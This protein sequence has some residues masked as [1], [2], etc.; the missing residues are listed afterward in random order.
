[1]TAVALPPTADAAT[2][3]NYN[4]HRRRVGMMVLAGLFV[5]AGCLWLAYWLMWGRFEAYTDDAYVH[6]NVVQVAPQVSGT[7]T[8]ILTDDTQ[9]VFQNQE[10]VTLD[11]ADTTLA[12]QHAKAKLAQTVRQVKQYFEMRDAAKAVLV[13]REA[14]LVKAK[15]DLER[16]QGLVRAKAI[17]KEEKEHYRIA[18]VMARARYNDA[19]HQLQRAESLV[20]NTTVATH[21]LVKLAKANLRKAY[22]DLQRTRIRAPATGYIAKRSVEVGQ[23]VTRSTPLLAII[24]LGEV[25]VEANFK[26]SQLDPI[27]LKQPVTL[28]ADAYP[29]VAYHGIVEGLSMGTGSVFSL[30]PPQNATGNWIKIV[31][32]LPVRIRLDPK[33]V[34]H[35][36]LRLG[37][38]MRVTVDVHHQEGPRLSMTPK[39]EV[40]YST[41]IYDAELAPTKLL[42]NRIIEE[43]TVFST[44]PQRA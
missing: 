8:S 41:P 20:A 24:P 18:F 22:L 17:S 2:V 27:R 7:V 1:M 44:A 25:W 28:Y 23:Q 40:Q 35:Y 42:I 12:F 15:R 36:P 5:I 33:E 26:E 29:G 30:L 32:R 13:L 14:A 37:L 21:P 31:Q 6:G 39:T 34:A 38:S 19:F 11:S 10:L 16:R 4:N 9:L 43:N 3:P